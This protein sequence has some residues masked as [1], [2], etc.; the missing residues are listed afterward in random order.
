M[1]KLTIERHSERREIDL[2]DFVR[3]LWRGRVVIVVCMIIAVLAAIL[4]LNI[5]DRRYTVE[6]K[7]TPT[8]ASG[9]GL[10]ASLGQLGQVASLVGLRVPNLQTVP[11]FQLYI[12]AISL[13]ETAEALSTNQ[14]FM[15]KVFYREWDETA[16]TWREPPPGVL[17]PVFAGIRQ[18]IGSPPYVWRPPDAGRLHEYMKRQIK[19]SQPARS[20]VA[21][22]T[23]KHADPK[24]AVDFLTALNKAVDTSLR[25]NMLERTSQYIA[26][27][28][29]TLRTVTVA[30]HRLALSQALSEQ[31]KLRM[32]ASSSAPYAAEVFSRPTASVRPTEP[33]PT[34]VLLVAL[35][36]GLIV[37][38]LIARARYAAKA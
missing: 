20:P 15:T 17:A 4:F 26:Y 35:A 28:S 23:F 27:L 9:A 34:L 31:E 16:G 11:P 37:G 5:S 1:N 29:Q 19:I 30:E 25:Q 13:R 3:S 22:I 33:I 12:E 36:G 24:F 38:G 21:T 10:E 6:L 7:V 18:L 2:I 14:D 32:M 8:T